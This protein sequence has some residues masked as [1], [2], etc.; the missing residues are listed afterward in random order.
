MYIFLCELLSYKTRY[1][2]C[3]YFCMFYMYI[4]HLC[5]D[6]FWVVGAC[7]NYKVIYLERIIYYL[8]QYLD[9]VYFYTSLCIV[10]QVYCGTFDFAFHLVLTELNNLSSAIYIPHLLSA[11]LCLLGLLLSFS[12]ILMIQ[13]RKKVHFI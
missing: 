1:T 5:S 7:R 3:T 11:C 4:V 6:L 12:S 9:F 13:I 10:L 8:L 2:F